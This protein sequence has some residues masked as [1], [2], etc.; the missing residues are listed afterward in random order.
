MS[1][2]WSIKFWSWVPDFLKLMHLL[3]IG[4][5]KGKSIPLQAWTSPEDPSR[6]RF[7]DFKKIGT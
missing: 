4:K 6:L 2:Y 7:P 3:T 5:G 1:P